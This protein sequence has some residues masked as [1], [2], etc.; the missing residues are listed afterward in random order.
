MK[1]YIFC[2]RIFILHLKTL[3]HTSK[4]KVLDDV[5]HCSKERH[6][7]ISLTLLKH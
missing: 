5:L 1:H 6:L 2:L 4:Y 3:L 7:D